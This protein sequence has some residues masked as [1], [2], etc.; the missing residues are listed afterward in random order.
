MLCMW[1]TMSSRTY[2]AVLLGICLMLAEFRRGWTGS[3]P[4]QQNENTPCKTEVAYV[5]LGGGSTVDGQQMDNLKWVTIDIPSTAYTICTTRRDLYTVTMSSIETY[6]QLLPDDVGIGLRGHRN[7]TISLTQKLAANCAGVGFIPFKEGTRMDDVI[8]ASLC[9][10]ENKEYWRYEESEDDA[11]VV[12]AMELVES[13]ETTVSGPVEEDQATG[14]WEARERYLQEREDKVRADE[15]RLLDWEKRLLKENQTAIPVQV[16]DDGMCRSIKDIYPGVLDGNNW[17]PQHCR[18][19]RFTIREAVACIKQNPY[20]AV[21]DSLTR[22]Y[23]DHWRMKFLQMKQGN[24]S[25][26]YTAHIWNPSAA[27]PFGTMT[28]GNARLRTP[29]RDV[30][31]FF[32]TSAK[33]VLFSA[34]VWDIGA[35]HC[36]TDFFYDTIKE[37]IRMYRKMANPEA[38]FVIYNIPF[39]HRDKSAWAEKCNL[40]EKLEVYREMINTLASCEGLGVF[41]IYGLQ[42]AAPSY[43]TDGVHIYEKGLDAAGELLLNVICGDLELEYPNLPC[44]PADEEA[45]KARWRANPVANRRSPKCKQSDVCPANTTMLPPLPS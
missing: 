39:I 40:P 4:A 5:T 32:Q 26:K 31:D 2:A 44:S 22:F 21:G 10:G 14:E 30:S 42:K 13:E 45:A 20:L 28:K 3:S 8:W 33:F 24:I 17:K 23:H 43:S 41:H 37:K 25:P 29:S 36:G 9:N 7:A 12:A 34:G 35:H 19:K 6:K 11:C 15:K 38:R 1:T 27:V 18:L 16:N